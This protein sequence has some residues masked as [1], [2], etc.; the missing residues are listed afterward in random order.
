MTEREHLMEQWVPNVFLMCFYVYHTHN[1]MRIWQAS[2]DLER[3]FGPK[4][5]KKKWNRVWLDDKPPVSWMTIPAFDA[6]NIQLFIIKYINTV[7]VWASIWAYV[8]MHW[9]YAYMYACAG[10]RKGVTSPARLAR[11]S[12]HCL[13]AA[14]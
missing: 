2:D 10:V 1:N 3:N 11:S 9:M 6:W 5:G 13:S 12:W 8:Y 14:A 7:T 4:K